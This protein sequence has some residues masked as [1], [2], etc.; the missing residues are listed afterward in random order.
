MSPSPV[1]GCQRPRI[2]S[3][4]SGAGRS[5]GPEAGELAARA[6]LVLNPWQQ[7]CLDEMLTLR[8]DGK[9]RAFESAIIVGRQNGKGAILEARE[10]AGLFLLRE[11]LLIHTSH[12]FKTSEEAF[13]R[14][15]FL[16][17]NTDDLYRRVASMP[18]SHGQEAINLKPR[19][20]L[21]T[22][23][24]GKNIT[25]SVRQRLRFLARSQGSGRGFSGDLLVLRRGHVP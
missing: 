2:Y 9:W 22:G 1:M 12:E 5:L 17:D 21:I 18:T 3:A 19:P 10:L 16:I 8:P 25:R 11:R 20:T 7:W 13:L 24:D 14:I 6:G 23:S 15:K 4:P